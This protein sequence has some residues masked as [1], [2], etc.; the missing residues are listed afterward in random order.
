M[1]KLFEKLLIMT[2]LTAVI[3]FSLCFAALN[4]N[5]S[6]EA[7]KAIGDIAEK[8][9][10]NPGV[11]EFLGIF[12]TIAVTSDVFITAYYFSMIIAVPFFILAVMSISQ[13]LALLFQ[14]GEEKQWKLITGKV[15]T[16][17]TTVLQVILCLTILINIFT[18]VVA[19]T[20]I[21]I[22]LLVIN[23]IFLIFFIKC[24]KKLRAGASFNNK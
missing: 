22:G 21:L 4:F 15:F 5:D 3:T 16:W 11:G 2:L 10:N 14:I 23:I 12:G 1:R 20:P 9:G 8:S 18:N 17:I 13:L 24:L 7:T 19:S 6:F